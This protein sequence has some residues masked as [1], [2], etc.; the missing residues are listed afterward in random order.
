VIRSTKLSHKFANFAQREGLE[1]FIDE[2]RRVAVL[3]CTKLWA[4]NYQHSFVN[5][6]TL[7]IDTWLGVAP[8]Q[9]CS[10]QVMGVI[11]GT[12]K[13]RKALKSGS[14]EV[15]DCSQIEPCL[16][17]LVFK[18]DQ[19]PNNSFDFWL[20]LTNLS[21]RKAIKAGGALQSLRL[22]LKSTRHC[23]KLRKQGKLASMICLSKKSVT[24][25]FNLPDHEPTQGSTLGIDV[26]IAELASP[27]HNRKEIVHPHGWTMSKIQSRLCQKKKGSHN[28][29]DAQRLRD[30]FVGWY[31]NQLNLSG[32]SQVKLEN[33]HDLRRYKSVDRFRG[34]W[35]YPKIFRKLESRCQQLGVQVAYINQRNTSRCC[36]ACGTVDAAS[37]VNK[38]F[39]CTSCGTKLDADFNAALNI[40][41]S[42]IISSRRGACRPSLQ[43]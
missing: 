1:K 15:P 42:E 33:I 11:K 22:P 38:V 37:R 40:E 19:E 28:F 7:G 17:F 5:V 30:N 26:G 9:S 32:V 18:L 6:K 39:E 25:I 2:Y 24:L 27:S 14:T 36:S 4:E 10:K 16:S 43:N 35:P 3:I 8:L 21:S 34:H 13:S 29:R 31:V 41:R 12:R 23:E 20:R